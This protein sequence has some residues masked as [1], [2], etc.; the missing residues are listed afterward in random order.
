MIEGLFPGGK[1]L[2]NRLKL[3]QSVSELILECTESDR[4]IW[5]G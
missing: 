5:T 2:Q 3:S 1:L 4:R